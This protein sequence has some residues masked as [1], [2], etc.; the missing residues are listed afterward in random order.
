MSDVI[1]IHKFRARSDWYGLDDQQRS[2]LT[3]QWRAVD[4]TG[5]GARAELV[6]RYSIRGQSDFSEVEVWTFAAISSNAT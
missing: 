6:G 5:A 1:W 4:T 2:E 3:E